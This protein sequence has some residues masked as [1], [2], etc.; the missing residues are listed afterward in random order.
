MQLYYTRTQLN[1]NRVFISLL[2]ER[3]SSFN[4]KITIGI[5]S[6]HLHVFEMT[7]SDADIKF[8]ISEIHTL[9]NSDL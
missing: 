6:I 4:D 3:H 8:V 2:I 1:R 5:N 9:K 7:T